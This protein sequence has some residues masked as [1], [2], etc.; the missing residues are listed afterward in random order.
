MFRV[1]NIVVTTGLLGFLATTSAWS[2]CT[3]KKGDVISPQDSHAVFNSIDSKKP[4]PKSEFETSAA[5]KTRLKAAAK[6]PAFKQ[7]VLVVNAPRPLPEESM[8]RM[9]QY[10]ADQQ[11]FEIDSDGFT[12]IVDPGPIAMALDQLYPKQSD[13]TFSVATSRDVFDLPK[14]YATNV[15]G[16][17]VEVSNAIITTYGIFDRFMTHDEPLKFQTWKYDD[18][19]LVGGKFYLPADAET[20][21]ALKGHI[22]FAVQYTPRA[23]YTMTT[24]YTSKATATEPAEIKF[25]QALLI[26]RIDC[27][28]I[29]DSASKVLRIVKAGYE[30]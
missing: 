2:A 17:T 14:T 26:G 12:H 23:P 10:N 25:N 3:L 30:R 8:A 24:G 27:L 1:I 16:A 29:T 5:Y 6:N 21:K 18:P 9:I 4:E 15:Y 28:A 7:T 22:K 19:S 13:F 20:A 11:R